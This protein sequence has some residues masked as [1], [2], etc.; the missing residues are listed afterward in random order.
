[1]TSTFSVTG[2]SQN[3]PDVKSSTNGIRIH[4]AGV[5]LFWDW[6]TARIVAREI[7]RLEILDAQRIEAEKFP[8]PQKS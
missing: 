2:I 5:A 3:Y 7:S 8:I 1:M 4:M 6:D